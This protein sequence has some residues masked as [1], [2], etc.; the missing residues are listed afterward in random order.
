MDPMIEI[1]GMTV[2]IAGAGPAGLTAAYELIKRGGCP[3]VFEKTGSVGGHAQT[4]ELDGYRFDIGG[5]RFFTKI[6][7]VEAIWREVMGDDL[8]RVSRESRIYCNH[9]FFFY[10][11]KPLNVV[12]GLGPLTSVL[13][14]ASFVKASL[15]PLHPENNFERWVINRF[16]RRLYEAFF[17]SYTE[18]VW[19]APCA[20]ISAE[21]AAQRIK[22]LSF[23]TV[24]MNAIL[25]DRQKKVKSLID[26]FL[27][28]RL[29]PG[30]LWERVERRVAEAGGHVHLRHDVRKIHRDR[31][32]VLGFTVESGGV[33]R[34][35]EGGHH[36]A[37]M[38]IT[39][40]VKRLDPQP[41]QEVIDASACLKYRDFLTVC[42]I[43]DKA[44]LFSDNWI[45]IH[46]PN[47]RMGRLQNF[48]NWSASMVPI[49]AKPVWGPNIL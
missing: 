25:G 35:V 18:K 32:R 38:P 31:A 36:I 9:R 27:Y 13:S 34:F 22:G 1:G 26:E 28:P 45:Y 24:V 14:A 49:L 7:E 29:R 21:W 3:I 20:E 41:P 15:F 44:D 17:K 43:V 12:A 30:E 33:E 19:G 5:H 46:D 2:L 37:S 4:E 39:H 40:V 16:G 10:P 48:K 11:L 6:L 47:V 8:L 42:V 23:R